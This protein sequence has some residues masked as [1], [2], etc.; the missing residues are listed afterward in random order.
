MAE[1]CV[2]AALFADERVGGRQKA[3]ITTRALIDLFALLV[4]CREICCPLTLL[5]AV[6]VMVFGDDGDDSRAPWIRSL[7]PQN[8][9]ALAFLSEV[10]GLVLVGHPEKLFGPS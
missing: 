3:E 7:R 8:A 9:L 6:L 1:Q 4:M 10:S 2:F 5:V